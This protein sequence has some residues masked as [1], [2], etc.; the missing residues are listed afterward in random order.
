M[1]WTYLAES[2]ESPKPWR[3]MSD[4]LPIVK[5]SPTLE[6]SFFQGWQTEAS[7]SPRYGTTLQRLLALR[8][9]GLTLSMV[10][11]PAKI[12][13]S[14]DAGKAWEESEASF[15]SR[16]CAWP[17]K[18][19]PVSYSLKTSLQYDDEVWELFSANLPPSGMTVDGVC[20]P[21]RT[22]ERIINENAG[23]YWRTPQA[24]DWKGPQGR[25]YKGIAMDLPAQVQMWPT[26]A[27]SQAHK[28]VRALAPSERMGN[29]GQ[30]TV[31][32]MGDRYPETIGGYL[33]PVWVEW[34]MGYP[35]GWTACEPWA[36]PSSPRKRG[37]RSSD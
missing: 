25:A 36:M 24:R 5:S 1:A 4:R 22:L 20:Y 14:Q 35:S 32:A 34:L 7:P 3:A 23:F 30:M 18:S 37:K 31:G 12:S 6:V 17:K 19:S 10:A 15:F 13:A 27:A 2:E 28:K 16:S 9:P 8:Y 26:P 33:N 29:H 21:L 11:S